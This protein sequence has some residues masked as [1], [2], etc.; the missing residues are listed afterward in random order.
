MIRK[1]EKVAKA[2]ER[3]DFWS[4][5]PQVPK[6]PSLRQRQAETGRDRQRQAETGRG[7]DRKRQAETGRDRQRQA[8][9][10]RDRHR[11]A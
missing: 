9:T 2:F 4:P 5:S 6:S 11:Q 8:E 10:G 7:R 1:H 3:R